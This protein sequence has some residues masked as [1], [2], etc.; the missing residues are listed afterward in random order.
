MRRSSAEN[1]H[2]Q[3]AQARNERAAADLWWEVGRHPRPAP[4]SRRALRLPFA[5]AS[6]ATPDPV[7]RLEEEEGN[8]K[9]M[10][11]EMR[12]EMK[13]QEEETKGNEKEKKGKGAFVALCQSICYVR[14]QAIICSV[15]N[16]NGPSI[17]HNGLG[18]ARHDLASSM[19]IM[20][21]PKK[22]GWAGAMRKLHR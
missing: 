15:H 3:E 4:R 19:R 7:E 17:V 22:K 6:R 5:L 10:R 1:P 11:E 12:G 9:E 8:E 18:W 14:S 2:R 21:K 16:A 13:E 20:I